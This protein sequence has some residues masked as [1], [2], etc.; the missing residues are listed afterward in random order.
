MGHIIIKHQETDSAC[1]R[2]CGWCRQ[3]LFITTED[4]WD[5]IIN[6]FTKE[7]RNDELYKKMEHKNFNCERMV[8]FEYLEECEIVSQNPSKELVEFVQTISES[9]EMA[10]FFTDFIKEYEKEKN[11]E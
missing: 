8:I 1:D 4:K 11:I 6:F 3:H 7:I 9:Y 10:D 2:C 5:K